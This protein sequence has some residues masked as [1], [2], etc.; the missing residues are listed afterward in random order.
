MENL[1]QNTGT[2]KK[3]L[4]DKSIALSLLVKPPPCQVYP[5]LVSGTHKTVRKNNRG[6]DRLRH[7]EFFK[8]V[9]T[10]KIYS[11]VLNL[12]PLL[13][14]YGRTSFVHSYSSW[15]SH[16]GGLFRKSCSHLIAVKQRLE[17]IIAQKKNLDYTRLYRQ[18]FFMDDHGFNLKTHK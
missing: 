10:W 3:C 17:Q 18:F 11:A 12:L 14:T 9:I 6:L 7:V 15:L 4:H 1:R 2:S 5:E 16:N 13:T 8:N